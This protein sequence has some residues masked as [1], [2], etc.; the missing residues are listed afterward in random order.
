MSTADR[1]SQLARRL[2]ALDIRDA[3][4]EETF[5]R[6]GGPGGQNVKK[7]S[8]SVML[9]HRPTGTQVKCQT[10]RRQG[11]N[12][13]LAREMLAAKLE[14]VR[15]SAAAAEQARRERVRRQRRGRSRH[16]KERM[17][18]DKSRVAAKKQARRRVE[19]D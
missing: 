18:A 11:L 16:A 19:V 13:L 15:K 10:T 8:T 12:R 2:A 9:V 4:L 14:A 1:E 3:D 5:V 7:T 6:S 17:L